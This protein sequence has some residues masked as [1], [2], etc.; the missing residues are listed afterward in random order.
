[1]TFKITGLKEFQKK[2]EG[3]EGKAD[4]L[5]GEH[6]VPFT[7]LFNTSFMQRYTNY[8]TM[9]AL[10][11][12]GGFKVESMDDFKNIPDQEWDEHIARTTRFA[13]WQEMMDKAGVEWTEKKLG[14]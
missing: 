2:L 13:N 14:F 9:D 7:E 3:L 5:H 4:A 10:I 12:A 6:E 8:A 11:D 1:M